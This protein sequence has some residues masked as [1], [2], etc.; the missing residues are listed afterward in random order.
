MAADPKSRQ[1]HR[2]SLALLLALPA[3]ALAAFWTLAA[4]VLVTLRCDD[5]CAIQGSPRWIVQVLLAAFGS[6][7]LVWAA[8]MNWRA[9]PRWG[10]IG[11]V[12]AICA[13]VACIQVKPV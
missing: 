10:L 6:A 4:V 13:F 1:A 7:A 12:V 2:R 3:V 8:W 11:L 9:A 5:P